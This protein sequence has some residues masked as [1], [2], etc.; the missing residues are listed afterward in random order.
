L[1]YFKKF[2]ISRLPATT[3]EN[4]AI[5]KKYMKQPNIKTI[6]TIILLF[7]SIISFSQLNNEPIYYLNLEIID[8]QKVFLNPLRIDSIKVT[9]NSMNGEVW[10]FT[11][12]KNFSW[13][14]LVDII[15]NYTNLKDNDKS[16]LF[17]INGKLIQDTTSIKIDDTYFIILGNG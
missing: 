2:K 10:F 15:K 17:K 9:K 7:K 8:L 12:N 14:S 1:K 5:K 16:L 3:W 13:Y 4:F 11:K 6:L